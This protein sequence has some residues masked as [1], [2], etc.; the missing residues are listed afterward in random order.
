MRR[1]VVMTIRLVTA[2]E[3]A[4][5]SVPSAARRIPRPPGPNSA[6]FI[7]AMLSGRV[8]PHGMFTRVAREHGRIAHIR[9]PNEHL[10]VLSHPDL[11]R[12]VFVTHGRSTMKGRGIQ[13]MR[14]LLGD[15]L[16]T[17]E[18]ELHRRQR[19][20]VQ[21]AFHRQRIAGYA[22]TM[23][24]AAL[25]RGQS[26][27]DGDRVDLAAEMSSLALDIV[28]RTLFG[29]DLSDAASE[30]A[31][32]LTAL[33][34]NFQRRMTGGADG[35]LDRLPTRANAR[36]QQALETLD[37]IIVRLIAAH[38]DQPETPTDNVLSMLLS[39]RDEEG[40]GTGMSDRQVRDEVMTLV[41]AGHETTAN[42]LTWAW[43][44]IGRHAEVAER[45]HAEVDMLQARPTLDSVRAL[46]WTH[47]VVAETLRLYP[48]AWTIGRRTTEDLEV[49][50][51]TLPA[52]SLTLASQW[53]L[54]RDPRWWG[55]GDSFRPDRWLDA[56]GAFD[57]TAPG[58][59]K[60]AWFPFGLG[61]RVCIG[62][63]FAWTEA[64]LVLATLARSWAPIIMADREP[65]VRPAV[66]LRPRDGMRAVLRQR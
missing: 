42:A 44:L 12:S 23:V 14:P 17:S 40:D 52:G 16:L 39:A 11:V 27:Q 2:G 22:D 33:L 37:A 5:G 51:W 46:P 32:A 3:S 13:Q 26:W 48:P 25:E 55:D 28:G 59:P 63:S 29:T 19:R 34:N 20:L 4:K 8:A 31:D 47:A 66:T 6:A 65:A 30:V 1:S 43:F 18:G 41:L 36:R 56:D 45:L 9:L 24:A 57:E 38:R 35:L 62:E 49:D 21:P 7:A 61:A 64:V 54:H 10:Y 60:G 58:Q 15:G 50:G 53:V